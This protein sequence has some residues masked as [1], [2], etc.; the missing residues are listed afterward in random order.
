MLLKMRR[1]IERNIPITNH[2]TNLDMLK[3]HPKLSLLLKGAL[4]MMVSA[5]TMP[6]SA[7]V[8]LK[9]HEPSQTPTR[10]VETSDNSVTVT[11]SFPEMTQV[12][13]DNYGVYVLSLVIDGVTV[14]TKKIIK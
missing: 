12:F 10:N 8:S 3:R 13:T 14:D 2:K 4:C 1:F 7:K 5:V 11:Y 6:I 9:I